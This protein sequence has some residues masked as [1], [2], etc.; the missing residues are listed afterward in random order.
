MDQTWLGRS[1]GFA[2][3]SLPLFQGSLRV[4][5]ASIYWRSF[6]WFVS[7][8]GEKDNHAPVQP[9][10]EPAASGFGEFLRVDGYSLL[11]QS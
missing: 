11:T 10:C 5:V 1:G 8:V 3:M 2:P 7:L 6:P 4:D 9:V